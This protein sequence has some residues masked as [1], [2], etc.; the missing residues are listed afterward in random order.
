MTIRKSSDHQPAK[1]EAL[2]KDVTVEQNKQE[3]NMNPFLLDILIPVYSP[4]YVKNL[5]MDS[6][7]SQERE[8]QMSLLQEIAREKLD[9]YPRECILLLLSGYDSYSEIGQRLGI[10]R[11]TVRKHIEEAAKRLKAHIQDP[12]S[13]IQFPACRWQ[14]YKSRLFRLDTTDEQNHFQSFINQ[15]EVVHLALSNGRFREAL[16]VYK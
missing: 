7:L 15:H 5:F 3:V 2:L 11:N 6:R 9:G 1:W 10:A 14:R 4:D 13:E 16:I 8:G 12:K